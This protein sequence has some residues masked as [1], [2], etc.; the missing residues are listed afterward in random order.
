[1]RKQKGIDNEHT[2]KV[3]SADLRVAKPVCRIEVKVLEVD[4]DDCDCYG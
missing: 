4:G 3:Y 2:I 1:M